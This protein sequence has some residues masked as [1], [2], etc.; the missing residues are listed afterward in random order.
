MG[1]L[2]HEPSASFIKQL[3]E[4]D[5]YK[6]FVETG[7]YTG[8]TA[9]WASKLF[10]R[11]FTV[12]ISKEF[13]EKAKRN[14]AG[15]DNIVFL[16]GRSE[17][18]L[19]TILRELHGPA[20]FWLD[21]HAGGGSYADKDDCPLLLELGL[22]SARNLVDDLIIID[23]ARGFLAPPPPPF[24]AEVWPSIHAVLDAV[25][26]RRERYIVIIADM[27]ICAPPRLR[28]KIEAFCAM[29]RPALSDSG[30]IPSHLRALFTALRVVR[31]L[32]RR[33]AL[34]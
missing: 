22:L 31:G 32:W 24:D 15:Q 18:Q 3:V 9:L 10:S 5:K 8:E 19:P 4:Q 33:V 26:P 23:D 11:V 30:Q 28:D 7:T 29:V 17:E 16:L 20:I 12:E 21:A 27:I 25:D 13:Q 14:C 34:G 6:E 2:A 1:C